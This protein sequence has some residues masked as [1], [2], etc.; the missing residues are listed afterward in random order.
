MVITENVQR[1]RCRHCHLMIKPEELAGGYCPECFEAEGK[2]RDD[3]E[4][5]PAADNG[6]VRYRCEDCKAWLEREDGR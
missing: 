4:E 1:L 5:V 3:F 6:R 2:K